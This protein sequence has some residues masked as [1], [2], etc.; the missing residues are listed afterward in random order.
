MAEFDP[1]HGRRRGRQAGGAPGPS[2]LPAD[3]VRAVD[4]LRT[5]LDEEVRL[6][7]LAEV[8]GVRPR[9]I[10]AHFRQFLGTTPLGWL[11]NARLARARQE[12][13]RAGPQAT[14]TGIAAASGFT[15]LGRFAGDYR[16]RFGELPSE[17]LRRRRQAGC[18]IDDEVLRLTWRAFPGA[19]AVAPKENAAALED[20]G[21]AQQLAPA[22]GLAKA[23]AA[24]CWAQR[25]AQHFSSTPGKDLARACEMAR[26]ACALAPDDAMTLALA[27]GALMLAHR[28][29][30]AERLVEQALARDPSSPIAWARRGWS[31]AYLGDSG[32]ALNE[33]RTTLHLAPFEPIRHLAFIGIGCAHFADGRYER[34][35]L[36]V[37]SGVEAYPQSFWAERILIAAAAHS[38][39]RAEARR[40]ARRFLRKDPHL[41]IAE[42]RTAW[43]FRP[44]FMDRLCDGL[45]IAGLPRA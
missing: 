18:A 13:L 38:G 30:E 7:T 40:I 26:V 29:E 27:G 32:G 9:T 44:Q 4:W 23:M 20:L 16:R 8:A 6:D 37:R 17:T 41:T 21:L 36:W 43:P 5:H 33:F 12:L 39:A 11:R 35:A 15:Q 22:Y 28:I 34:A 45:A 19:F 14:V 24:W 25:A 31:S 10:E 3:V 2:A 42:A 1:T